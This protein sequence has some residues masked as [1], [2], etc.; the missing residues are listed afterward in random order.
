MILLP[1]V[2]LVWVVVVEVYEVFLFFDPKTWWTLLLWTP[3]PIAL[4]GMYLQ[5]SHLRTMFV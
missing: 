4:A 5:I 3:R 2:V 1:V